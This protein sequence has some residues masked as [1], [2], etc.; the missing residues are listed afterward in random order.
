MKIFAN[1]T[2]KILPHN[3]SLYADEGEHEDEYDNKGNFENK[4]ENPL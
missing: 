4:K 3:N 1:L 2:N